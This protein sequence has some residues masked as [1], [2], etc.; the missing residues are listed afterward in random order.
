MIAP[1]SPPVSIGT[2]LEPDW[3]LIGTSPRDKRETSESKQE[4]IDLRTKI[5]TTNNVAPRHT[6]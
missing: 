4:V 2:S 1:Y 3:N 6:T 5:S